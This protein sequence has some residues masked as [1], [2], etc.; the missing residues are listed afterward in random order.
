MTTL[1]LLSR[2]ASLIKCICYAVYST[3]PI[4]YSDPTCPS[5]H[6]NYPT[7]KK[8]LGQCDYVWYIWKTI[9]FWGIGTALQLFRIPTKQAAKVH[10]ALASISTSSN[11]VSLR[12]WRKLFDSHQIITLTVGGDRGL[13]TR[14]QHALTLAKVRRIA[15]SIAVHYKLKAWHYFM[16]NLEDRPNHLRELKPFTLT[17][18]VVTYASV[19][20][21]VGVCQDPG[22]HYFV[23]WSTV[24]AT[25][26]KPLLLF[27]N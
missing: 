23:W 9:I 15:L 20:G 1:F 5:T 10:K 14:L 18:L 24:S 27:N 22:S 7:Y 2:V 13:F 25:T 21:M 6:R 26:Q 17:W 19:T 11:K 16:A 3:Q 12:K 4:E 8:K